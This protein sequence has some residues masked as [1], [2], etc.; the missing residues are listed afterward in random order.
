MLVWIVLREIG[1]SGLQ[2]RIRQHV[3]FARRLTDIARRQ[4]RLEALVDP[5]LSIA[6][7]RYR[8]PLAVG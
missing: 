6:A 1:R 2:A 8:P 3:G 7:I 5:E 4:P